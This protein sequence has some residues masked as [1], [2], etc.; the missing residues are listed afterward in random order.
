MFLRY[1]KIHF[2]YFAKLSS[3]KKKNIETSMSCSILTCNYIVFIRA[4]VNPAG[5]SLGFHSA[6]MK[7]LNHFGSRKVF[8]SLCCWWRWG[9][10]QQGSND[11]SK[12]WGKG[13]SLCGQSG[14]GSWKRNKTPPLYQGTEKVKCTEKQPLGLMITP[15]IWVHYCMM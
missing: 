11:I 8:L 7:K 2:F 1:Q 12:V 10:L 4:Y 9:Y 3:N 14:V 6:C 15:G 5:I 13:S